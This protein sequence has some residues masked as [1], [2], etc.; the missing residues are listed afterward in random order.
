MTTLLFTDMAT[1]QAL[2]A[3]TEACTQ[4]RAVYGQLA[5]A[6]MIFVKDEGIY[7]MSTGQPILPSLTGKGARVCYAAGFSPNV[8]D[9]WDR[10]VEAVG[11]DDFAEYLPLDVF[12][13][14]LKE[15]ASAVFIRV[16]PTALEIGFVERPRPRKA[17]TSEAALIASGA[18]KV[19]PAR[20]PR[21]K[22][23]RAACSS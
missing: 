4:H 3:H 23:G 12:R 13:E 2:V 15:Q 5:K 14:A 17:A 10:C 9:C 19:L 21:R 6:G 18:C 8:A 1:I 22:G 11:G 7:L 16:S 20:K